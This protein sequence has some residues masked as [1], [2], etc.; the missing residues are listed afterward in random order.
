[1]RSSRQDITVGTCK[2]A[3]QA[4]LSIFKH[5]QH[6][7]AYPDIFRYI[8]TKSVIFRDYSSVWSE[9][10]EPCVTLAYSEPWHI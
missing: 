4:D 8:G 6:I 10:S 9:Y 2:K 5:I 7:Q 3:I 1:M